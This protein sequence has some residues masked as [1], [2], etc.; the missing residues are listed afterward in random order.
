M[1]T[2]TQGEGSEGQEEE[3]GEG[4]E[5]EKGGQTKSLHHHYFAHPNGHATTKHL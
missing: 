5:G 4:W 2:H 1:H 3:G